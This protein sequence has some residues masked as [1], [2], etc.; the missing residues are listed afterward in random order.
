M[1]IGVGVPSRVR[2]KTRLAGAVVLVEM[3]M[4]FAVL[5]C[6]GELFP[7]ELCLKCMDSWDF[8]QR[9]GISNA[10]ETRPRVG[11]GLLAI[12]Y[13][14]FAVSGPFRHFVE[15]P[16]PGNEDP[17]SSCST[18]ITFWWTSAGVFR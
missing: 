14:A 2:F 9:S 10:S 15:T 16:A 5:G 7:G 8:R 6:R 12:C 13:S 17:R 18:G 4:S 3:L 11:P 1:G